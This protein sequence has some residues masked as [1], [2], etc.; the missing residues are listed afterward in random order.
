MQ[1]IVYFYICIHWKSEKSSEEDNTKLCEYVQENTMC[2]IQF[3]K[4]LSLLLMN[5]GMKHII[6]LQVLLESAFSICL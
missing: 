5:N 2:W 1:Y 3:K 4:D 6:V